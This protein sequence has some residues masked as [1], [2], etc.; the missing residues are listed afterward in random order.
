MAAEGELISLLRQVVELF[1]GISDLTRHVSH[2]MFQVAAAVA[3][4]D[5]AAAADGGPLGSKNE[6]TESPWFQDAFLWLRPGQ[7]STTRSPAMARDVLDT[8]VGIQNIY[9]DILELSHLQDSTIKPILD[10]VTLTLLHPSPPAFHHT[11]NTER[12]RQHGWPGRAA[13]S[14]WVG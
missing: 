3:S 8:Y 6:H 5:P 14:S 11:Y 1:T 13:S 2:P 7:A 4:F 12:Q 9:K 10:E